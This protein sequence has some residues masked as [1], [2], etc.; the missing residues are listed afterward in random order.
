M[1]TKDIEELR[2]WTLQLISGM[3][4]SLTSAAM[5]EGTVAELMK[6]SRKSQSNRKQITKATLVARQYLLKLREERIA[7]DAPAKAKKL[8]AATKSTAT[9]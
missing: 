4:G 2:D 5:A 9:P 1:A 8:R 7:N 3:D 6:A